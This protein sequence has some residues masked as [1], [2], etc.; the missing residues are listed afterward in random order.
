MAAIEKIRKHSPLIITIIGVALLAFVLQD[1]FQSTNRNREYNIAVV[2]GEKIPYQDFSEKVEKNLENMRKN[3]GNNLTSSQTYS[4]HNNTLEQMI[5]DDIMTEEY[6]A[7]GMNVSADELYD[8]FMGEEPH[9]WVVQNFSDA[10]GNFNKEMVQYYLENL[11]DLPA[12]NR[13]QWLDFERAVK[14]NRLETK[15][16][17]LLKASYFVPDKLAEK[18]YENKN[19]KATAE[20]VALRYTTIPD[21]LV[22]VTPEDNKKFYEENKYKFETD[23]NRDIEYVVFDIQPSAKDVEEAKAFIDDVANEFQTTDNVIGFV[24]ANSDRKYDSTWMGRKDVPATIEPVIF[25]QGNPKGFVYGPYQ[26]EKTFNIV[27]IVDLKSRPDSLRAS[28]ILIPF[29]GA[30]RSTDSVTTKEQASQ[31]ADS[32]LNVLRKSPKDTELF[33]KLASQFSSDG[34]K[35]KGGDL[36]WFTDGMMVDAFNEFVVNNPV[37]TIGKVETPYGYHIIKVTDKTAAQP[38]ARLAFMTHEIT[39]S[40]ETYQNVFAEANKFVTENRTYDDFNKAIEAQGLTKRSMPRMTTSTVE[41]TGIDNPRQIVRW[42]FDSKTKLHDISTIFDLDNMFVIAALTSIVPEGYA[43]LDVI[44]EQYKY[45]ILNEKKGDMAVEKMKAC[46]NDQ[47]RMVNELGA[48]ATTVSDL[49]LESRVL[50]NFG[51][52]P[53]IIGTI[54]GMK[55][56]MSEGP[57]AGSTCAFIIKNVK[58]TKAPATKDF[59]E[60]RREKKSQFDNKVLNEAVYSALR[61]KADIKDNRAVFY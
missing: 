45:Q 35:D 1:L 44:A 49:S 27:R 47:Q 15:F 41:I 51:V 54:M 7:L 53:K 48:E 16:N 50:G 57:V 37:G 24:N 32:I 23:A 28:H 17:N 26:D 9:E 52:E 13:T 2:N 55:E 33:G 14:E 39:A 40:T 18:Y 5:K 61:D 3:Y 6:D 38:K 8:Q 34:S 43:P 20:I 30:I 10:N 12:E 60:V 31:L 59:T 19:D 4:I 42:A 56:N 21:S 46:G 29:K 11:Q 25:D 22:V 36:E 58:S